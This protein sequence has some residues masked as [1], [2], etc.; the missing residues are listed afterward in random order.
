MPEGNPK[1]KIGDLIHGADGNLYIVSP[2]I[3]KT[4]NDGSIVNLCYK[5]CFDSGD[6]RRGNCNNE[7]RCRAI[8]EFK[9]MDCVSII[10]KDAI[11][12]RISIEEDGV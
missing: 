10:N 6:K 1:Y 11:F 12:K 8:K 9:S 5:C 7:Y 2:G 4:H 3:K